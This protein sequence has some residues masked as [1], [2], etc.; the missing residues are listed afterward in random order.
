MLKPSVC[1]LRIYTSVTFEA[2]IF[3]TTAYALLSLSYQKRKEKKLKKKSIKARIASALNA[4]D[5]AGGG[6]GVS[7]GGVSG[8][9]DGGGGEGSG[10]D[11]DDDEEDDEEEESTAAIEEKSCDVATAASK[12]GTVASGGDKQ[13]KRSKRLE[14]EQQEERARQ[15]AALQARIESEAQQIIQQKQLLS[16]TAAAEVGATAGVVQ[17]CNTCG[18]GFTDAVQY[19]QHF[20]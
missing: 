6:A 15:V 3:T 12:A 9:G 7:S 11:E 19:R 4:A 18:G 17:R 16:A 13:G 20:R 8:R 5:G 1:Y 2:N 14:K 10:D